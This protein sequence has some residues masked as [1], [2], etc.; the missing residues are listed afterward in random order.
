[1]KSLKNRVAVI[2]AGSLALA[3]GIVGSPAYAVTIPDGTSVTGDMLSAQNIIVAA[4]VVLV[5]WKFFKRAFS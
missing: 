4:L 3:L 2:R 5:G 1:M